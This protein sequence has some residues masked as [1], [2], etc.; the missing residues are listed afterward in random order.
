M[1]M[2]VVNIGIGDDSDAPVE[3]DEVMSLARAR[4]TD[5]RTHFVE[6]D[7]PRR[8]PSAFLMICVVLLFFLGGGGQQ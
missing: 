3:V 7:R 8:R 5:E 4:F 6:F 1:M 2:H